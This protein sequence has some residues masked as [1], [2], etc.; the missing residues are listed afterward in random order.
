MNSRLKTFRIYPSKGSSDQRLPAWPAASIIL[1]VILAAI[2]PPGLLTGMNLYLL[3]LAL[4]VWFFS[5][6]KFDPNLLRA[7]VPFGLIIAIGLVAGIGSDQYLYLKDAWYMSNPAVIMSVGYVLYLC[8]PDMARGLRAFV[9]GGTLIGLFFLS[10]FATRPDLIF[11]SS[12]RIRETV[13]TGYY[14][15]AL[16]FTILCAYF[17]KWPEGL[18][19]PKWLALGCLVICTLAVVLC[20]SRTMTIVAIIGALGAAGMFG[21]HGWQRITAIAIF[22]LLVISILRLSVDV[23]SREA[24]HTFVGKLARSLDEMNVQE[25]T[26]FKSINENWRGYETAM[27]LKLYYSGSPAEW[28]FGHGFGAQVDLGFGMALGGGVGEQRELKRFIPILHNGYAYLLV[29]GGAVAILI[30]G[31]F[32]FWLYGIGHRIVTSET[33]QIAFAPARMLQAVVVTLAVT[34]WVVSGVF[35]KLDMFPFLLVAGFLLAAL[36]RSQV[37]PR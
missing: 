14:A 37:A 36:T 1:L 8:K 25:Y 31:F 27:A 5:G 4:L 28:L 24:Q 22:G 20:F 10:S 19:L 17:R 13:G 2:F 11:Q 18:A 26:D 16:A 15:P 34:T 7:I 23:E 3:L 12:V 35:N 9:I 21:R 30:F 33:S 6:E 29:K 32:L